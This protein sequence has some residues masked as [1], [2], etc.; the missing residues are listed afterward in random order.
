M[1]VCRPIFPELAPHFATAP[2]G[3]DIA[4]VE[5][6]VVVLLEGLTREL[7]AARPDVMIEFRQTYVGPRLRS[8]A[9]MIRVTDCAMDSTE[10]RVHALDLRL[11][12][13]ETVVHSDMVMWHPE[14]SPEVAANQLI[15]ILFCV[16]QISMR[17]A[18]LSERHQ[19]MLRFWLS[20]FDE[21]RA[22][23][24]RG[25]LSP[26]RPDLSYPSVRADDGNVSVIALYDSAFCHLDDAPSETVVVVNGTVHDRVVLSTSGDLGAFN[27]L[28][29][30]C[31][32]VE[33]SRTS[34]TLS[35][36]PSVLFVPQ[37]GVAV[38]VHQSIH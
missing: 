34:L 37:S 20:I 33:V 7:T 10:N 38:L 18:R 1:L 17:L 15:A 36:N 8:F 30:D 11:I 12:A 25:Q 9:N 13:G 4:S 19:A 24:L 23:L 2:A 31:M 6:A 22:V 16:P 21:Y 3:T 5:S 35:T 26:S 32:G 29:R 28:V 27:V 14:A